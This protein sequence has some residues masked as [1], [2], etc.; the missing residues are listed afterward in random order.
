MESL[1]K[2]E[3]C[4][5]KVLPMIRISGFAALLQLLVLLG[6][7]V[8]V[9]RFGLRPASSLGYFELMKDSKLVGLLVDDFTSIILISLYLF[10]FS[11]LFL[12]VFKNNFSLALIG[13][14]LT[15]AAVV[16]CIASHSGFSLMYLSDKYWVATDDAI[17]MQLIAAGDSIIAQNIWNSTAGFFAGVFLQGGGIIM[18]AAMMGD[19]NFTKLTIISGILSNGLDLI[20]HLIH[21]SL[22]LVA[23]RIL[24]VAGPIYI[25]WFIMLA[26]DLL[27]YVK[28]VRLQQ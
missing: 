26:K 23:E 11:G 21:Y 8:V 20:Q 25:I 17:K 12:I 6:G 7:I 15:F 27:G 14:L 1:I 28:F 9:I 22:P 3:F 5:K 18:S 4:E 13:T 10:T 16:I 2:K 24:M 19:K